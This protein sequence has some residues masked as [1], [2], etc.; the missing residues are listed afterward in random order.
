MFFLST[1]VFFAT[2][3]RQDWLKCHIKMSIFVWK[4]RW[5]TESSV[6]CQLAFEDIN[7]KLIHVETS[8]SGPDPPKLRSQISRGFVLST[9]SIL[10]G[11]FSFYPRKKMQQ[12]RSSLERAPQT[13]KLT[14]II[15]LYTLKT[16]QIISK[17][18]KAKCHFSSSEQMLPVCWECEAGSLDFSCC[19]GGRTL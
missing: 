5:E 12:K 17:N 10:G 16:T 7:L 15:S 19:L 3:F 4:K 1:F 6:Q 9:H 11:T 14:K 8:L 18:L 13:F 2:L